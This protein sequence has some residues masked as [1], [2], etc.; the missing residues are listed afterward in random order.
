MA[1]DYWC[2]THRDGDGDGGGD[3]KTVPKRTMG[4]TF[5]D[6]GGE[7]ATMSLQ[8][9]DPLGQECTLNHLKTQY[10]GPLLIQ[11]IFLAS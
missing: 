10:E 1:P 6:D 2:C 11:G 3:E 4:T 9:F 8:V 5:G 7:K